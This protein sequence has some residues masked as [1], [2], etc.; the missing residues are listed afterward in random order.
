MTLLYKSREVVCE[1]KALSVRTGKDIQIQHDSIM[2]HSNPNYATEL[3]ANQS[4]L[5]MLV[6][7]NN[8]NNKK[9]EAFETVFIIPSKECAIS[10]V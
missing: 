2:C 6:G 5:S 8:Q 9:S 10:T 4:R 1:K 7:R 3:V